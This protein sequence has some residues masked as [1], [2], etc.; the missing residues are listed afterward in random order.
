MGLFSRKK[1]SPEPPKFNVRRE[2]WNFYTYTYGEGMRAMIEFDYEHVTEDS[3]QGFPHCVR[4]VV[5]LPADDVAPN[6]LPFKE[7]RDAL[8]KTEADLLGML[9]GTDC[10]LAGTMYYGAMKDM[11]FQVNDLPQFKS[12]LNQWIGKQ[13]QKVQLIESEGWEF[14]DAK[15]MPDHIMWHQVTDRQVI[16][17]LLQVGSNPNKVHNLEHTFLGP[18][19]KLQYLSEQLSGDGFEQIA[20]EGERLVMM[21]PSDLDHEQISGLTQRLAGYTASIGIRYD[22][23]GCMVVK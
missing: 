21:K 16:G 19:D 13:K 20:L 12:M 10:R 22:G 7:T 23:W 11:V 2:A 14:F 17:Q 5:Q 4:A 18:A 8:N 3:H 6:G 9:G 1:K 15:V